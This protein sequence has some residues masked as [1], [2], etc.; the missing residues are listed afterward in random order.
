[1]NDV[2]AQV[3]K[4]KLVNHNVYQINLEVGA[5]N[6]IA[7]QYLLIQ[8]P[9]GESVPYSIGSAPQELPS[10]T[11]YILVEEEDS[12]AGRVVAHLK[13]EAQVSLKMPSGDC[14]VKSTKIN[15]QVDKVLLIAGGTGFAQMKSM[16]DSLTLKKP[17]VDI[18]LYWG[19]RTSE[20]TFLHEWIKS[21]DNVTVV[22]SEADSAWQGVTGWLYEKV[23]ADNN[24]RN[25]RVFVSGSPAMVYGTL[26]KLEEAGLPREA[27]YS[28]VFAYAPRPE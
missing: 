3:N 9:T 15:E 23:I 4:V 27:S 13:S 11:L 19:V 21:R 2:I 14:H 1:M 17:Q 28:D 5:E 25:T 18:A 26:D 20:D 8:L 7:G 12:L 10:I 16:Y 22:V 6:F 24:F